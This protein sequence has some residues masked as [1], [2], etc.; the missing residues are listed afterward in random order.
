M[1]AEES[2]LDL[3]NEIGTKEVNDEFNPSIVPGIKVEEKKDS[4][5]GHFEFRALTEVEK[6]DFVNSL[7]SDGKRFLA[8]LAAKTARSGDSAA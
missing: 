3:T 1:K 4:S 5:E 2:T 6:K 8:Q 7:N